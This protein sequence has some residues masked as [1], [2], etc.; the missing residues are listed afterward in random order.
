[1]AIEYTQYQLQAQVDDATADILNMEKQHRQVLTQI[2]LLKAL[3]LDTNTA[4]QITILQTRRDN[5]EKQ[6]PV[7]INIRDNLAALL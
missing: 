2:K 1:M 5:L 4:N 3:T 6:I 7:L